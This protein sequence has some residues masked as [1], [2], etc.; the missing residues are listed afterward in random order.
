MKIKETLNYLNDKQQ[1]VSDLINL[2]QILVKLNG[3]RRLA[4]ENNITLETVFESKEC[5]VTTISCPEAG[6]EFPEHSHTC[7]VEYLICL[8]GSFG[9]LL[10]YNGYRILKKKEC[11][12]IP[13]DILHSTVSLEKNSTLMCICLP[14]ESAYTS[15][16]GV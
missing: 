2:G 11:A 9:V 6:S 14:K 12:H 13:A 16:K 4:L 5:S 8:K 7:I 10:P 1:T 3:K 15:C